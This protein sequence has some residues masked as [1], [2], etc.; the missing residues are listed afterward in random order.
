MTRCVTLY[1][2]SF[3]YYPL[4]QKFKLKFVTSRYIEDFVFPYLY[5]YTTYLLTHLKL[6]KQTC[7]FCRTHICN[8]FSGNRLNHLHSLI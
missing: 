1:N 4:E 6:T 3:R 5:L 7:F 8:L 2:H